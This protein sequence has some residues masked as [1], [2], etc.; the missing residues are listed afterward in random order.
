[1]GK[2]DDGGPAFPLSIKHFEDYDDHPQTG[3]SLRHW[4]AGMAMQGF[5]VQS[6]GAYDKGPCNEAIVE[7]SCL[8]SDLLI[9]TLRKDGD[10]NEQ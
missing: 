6:T 2:I 1:M 5:C 3:M 10:P 9:A 7:R 4:F 8:I